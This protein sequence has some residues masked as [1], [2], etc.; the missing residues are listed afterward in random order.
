MKLTQKNFGTQMNAPVWM[1]AALGLLVAGCSSTSNPSYQSTSVPPPPAQQYAPPPPALSEEQMSKLCQEAPDT[2][3]HVQALEPLTLADVKVMAKLSFSPDVIINQVRK[4]HT[5]FQLT[6]S[7]IID[8]KNSGVSDQ[9][10]DFLISTPN[11]IAGSTPVPEPQTNPPTAQTPPPPPPDEVQIEGINLRLAMTGC[12]TFGNGAMSRSLPGLAA[13]MFSRQK[14]TMRLL[15]DYLCPADW[16]ID[17]FLRDYLYDTGVTIRGRRARL[18]WTARGWRANC[19]CRRTATNS[20][21]TSSAPIVLRQGVLHNPVNDRR[22][23]QGV[24]HVTEGGLPIPD[25]KKAVP[26]IVFGGCWNWPCNRRRSCC[27]CLSPRRRRRRRNVLFRC[28]SGRWFVRRCR[29]SSRRNRWKSA[30]SRRAIWSATW[31]SSKRFSATR[32]I[33]SCRKMTRAWT[34]RIGPATPAASSWRRIWSR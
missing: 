25:D 31:I 23:T 2:C 7:N 18:F 20:F 15:A 19:R 34:R 12:P 24:F 6:A 28:C 16:R 10:T 21:P 9:V 11:S 32:A 13:P 29:D 33:R 26:K 4:S 5:V 30:S 14:E 17:H 3:H 22:T 8:L 1:A 27:G